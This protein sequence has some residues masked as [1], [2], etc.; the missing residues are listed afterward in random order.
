MPP[1]FC[2]TMCDGLRCIAAR[3]FVHEGVRSPTMWLPTDT[4]T[5]TRALARASFGPS[6]M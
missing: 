4:V 1:M 2:Q 5:S 3:I 6:S